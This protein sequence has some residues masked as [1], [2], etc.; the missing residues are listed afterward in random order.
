MTTVRYTTDIK[1]INVKSCSISEY[2]AICRKNNCYEM[3]SDTEPVRPYFDIDYFNENDDYNGGC[4]PFV[5]E[6][7]KNLLTECFTRVFEVEPVFA[8][9]TSNSASYNDWKTGAEKWKISIHIVITNCKILKKQLKTVVENLNNYARSVPNCDLVGYK[10]YFNFIEAGCPDTLFDESVYNTNNKLRSPYASKPNENRPVVIAEGSFDDL[11]ICGGGADLPVVEYQEEKKPEKTNTPT[12]TINT[13]SSSIDELKEKAALIDIQYINAYKDWVNIVWA[14]KSDGEANIDLARDISKRSPK[15]EE[16]AFMKMWNGYK[17]VNNAISIGTFNYYCKKS[18]PAEYNKLIAKYNAKDIDKVLKS[19]TQENIAACFCELFKDEMLYTNG[20]FY[21]F[22]GVVWEKSHTAIRRKFVNEFTNI[23]INKQIYYLTQMR[24]YEADAPEYKMLQEKNKTITEIIKSLQTNKNIKDVCNDAIKTY[25]ENNEVE[26]ELNPYSFCFKDCVFDLETCTFKTPNINEYMTITTGY[27]Y[28]EPTEEETATLKEM[29]QKVFPDEKERTLYLT[30][31]ATGMFGKTLEKFILANGS[32]R[33]G[34]GFTNE[35]ALK[36]FGRYGYTCTNAVLMSALKG[37]ANQEIANM[38]LKRLVIYREPDTDQNK[39]L[40]C[41]TIKELTGGSKINARGLYSSNTDCLLRATHIL[42]CNE[43]PKITGE[44]D[45]AIMM[46]MID[47][48]F[49]STF[50]N[51]AADVDEAAHIYA[52]DDRVK[53]M[54]FQDTHKFA[55]FR[56]LVDYWKEYLAQNKNIERFVP[57]SITERSNRY[58]Q[59][60]NELFSWFAENY[61]KTDDA[62]AF[63]KL[64]DIYSKFINSTI[65]SNYNKA[66][67]RDCSKAKFIE[68]MSKNLFIKKAIVERHKYYDATG[69]RREERS[70]LVGYRLISNEEENEEAEETEEEV[71]M[72]E[73]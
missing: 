40:N 3:I 54:D 41:S 42:E 61:E 11:I 21:H 23:F 12:N 33:N 50:T 51:N 48:G 5:I 53:D 63:I 39:R 44:T 43:V 30:L 17:R 16:E 52:G 73:I 7:A 66:E 69:K 36:M 19:P 37:G 57:A 49:K 71:E 47:M 35:L 18:N 31:L 8:V 13:K 22:N 38:D 24:L 45:Q 67:K 4:V 10:A 64:A 46:R 72:V 1:T 32:G 14:L 6:M 2:E 60:S 62:K 34:K 58:L 70:V 27:D 56:I 26:F 28:R 25:L 68:K 29:F 55:L 20:E 15:Y 65:Y 9:A 59:K